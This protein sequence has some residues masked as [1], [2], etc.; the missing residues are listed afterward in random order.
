MINEPF[1]PYK[2]SWA[3]RSV[4]LSECW[5]TICSFELVSS[6]SV[7]SVH[8]QAELVKELEELE[9]LKVEDAYMNDLIIHQMVLKL[10]TS[11]GNDNYK[12]IFIDLSSS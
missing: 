3:I 4:A 1:V 6:S 11:V 10:T 5:L 7:Y 8:V 12:S 9:K 2:R